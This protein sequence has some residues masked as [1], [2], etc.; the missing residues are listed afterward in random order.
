[1]SHRLSIVSSCAGVSDEL[2]RP[3][4]ELDGLVTLDPAAALSALGSTGTGLTQAEAERR[5]ATY[6]ANELRAQQ[7]RF[8][9]IVRV[10]LANGFNLLLAFAGVLTAGL[11]DLPDG[12][13]ILVLL[14]LNVGLSIVQE[15]R[16]E[17]SLAALRALLPLSV[18]ALRD[19][20][21]RQIS[22]SAV[23]PGDVLPV[24]PGELVPADCRVLAAE[25]LTVDQAT[26]TGESVPQTKGR[27]PV[28][29]GGPVTSWTN[30][31]FSGSSVVSGHGTAVVVATGARTQFGRTAS[32][33]TDIRTPSDF[34][35][36]LESFGGFLVRWGLLIAVVVF[37]ANAALGRGVVV[38]LTLAVAVA[39][40]MVPEALPAVT[41]TSLALG[42]RQLAKGGVLLRRLAAVEDL[43]VIDTLCSDKTGTITEDR[44]ALT[45]VWTLLDR[46]V[47]LR[48]A[49]VCSEYPGRDLDIVDQAVVAAA[50]QAGCDLAEVG[51]IDRR[52]V[53]PFS[54]ETKRVAVVIR[55]VQ[56]TALVEK[57][58]AR[59]VLARCARLRGP[60]G[61]APIAARRSELDAQVGHWEREGMRVLGLAERPVTAAE[62]SGEAIDDGDLTLVGL[63]ALAD[64]PRPGAAEA[65][66]RAAA[67][68]VEVKIL[69]G[70]TLERAEALGTQVGIPAGE[71]VVVDAARLRGPEL[72]QLAERGRVFGAMVP[73]D[74]YRLVRALQALGHHVAVTGDGVND[75]PALKAADV[76][77][78]VATG[79]DVAKSAADAV[80]LASDLGVI[81]DGLLEG[82][83]LFT[84]INRYLLY[85]M[86]SNFA[87]VLI[88]A[89]A[90]LFLDFLPLTPEQVLLLNVLADLPMLALVSD[91]VG[92]E[93]I[94][95]PH[96]WELR[97]VM[98]LAL[99]L[100]IVNALF[101]FGLLA[102]MRGAPPATVRTAW[103]VLLGSSSLLVLLAVRTRGPLWQA[104]PLSAPLALAFGAGLVATFALVNIP[105]T[106][107]L[108]GFVALAWPVQ[109]GLL[110]LAL[111]YVLV[112]DMLEVFFFRAVVPPNRSAASR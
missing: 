94:A 92:Q 1:M 24:G 101:A 13:I 57:G 51:A 48:E 84:K 98:E 59:V 34:Q 54:S 33:V 97:R 18:W 95:R 39:L 96:R 14:A 4:N 8:R 49:V 100:G 35:V 69:T 102:A 86:V 40:G 31:L 78:A 70:D 88:V 50:K 58:A 99:Y 103:F 75:A 65:L 47:L 109:L 23:V 73:Q 41:A 60:S 20:T 37:V 79:A 17:R 38:S 22:V 83:R 45:D 106:Q 105:W 72:L 85:T 56:G 32:L 76:G 55:G 81:V 67:L 87:N 7:R 19:G 66:E 36:N 25:R 43:S 15:Y 44:T 89:V 82:R 93:E 3:L 62:A 12:A 46:G 91:R 108:L 68:G 6:G 111:L 42:S 29:P 77:I 107:E 26:L 53:L 63:L 10:Q 2:A 61:D 90:S 28:V 74:K 27:D 16:A 110:V 104:P 11:G 112:A 64:P 9:D 80:L 5:L 52:I 71:D 30:A 21:A